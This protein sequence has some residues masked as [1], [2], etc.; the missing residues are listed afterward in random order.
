MTSPCFPLILVIQALPC[1][2]QKKG[3]CSLWI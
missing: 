1:R 2:V 3:D